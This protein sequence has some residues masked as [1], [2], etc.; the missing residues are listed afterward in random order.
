[1]SKDKLKFETYRT[2][3]EERLVRDTKIISL[4]T[5]KKSF[6]IGI[7]IAQFLIVCFSFFC[8]N[9]RNAKPYC[10]VKAAPFDAH[11]FQVVM[12]KPFQIDDVIV[13]SIQ[14]YQEAL[15]IKK[16]VCEENLKSFNTK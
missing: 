15:T 14:P 3:N 7:M 10:M 8:Y 11:A 2:E 16:E 6:W 1:M 5:A 9:S 4:P 13:E 12:K